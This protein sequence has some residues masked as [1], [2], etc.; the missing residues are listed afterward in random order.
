M[1]RERYARHRARAARRQQT[2]SKTGREIGPPPPIRDPQRRHAAQTSLAQFAKTYFPNTFYLPFCPDHLRCIAKLEHATLHGGHFAFALPRGSGKTSLALTAALWAVLHGYRQFVVIIGPTERHALNTL[3]ALRTHLETNDLLAEDYPEVCHPIRALEGITNRCPGQLC[4]NQRTQIQFTSNKIVLPTIAESPASGSILVTASITGQIRGMVHTRPDGHT[5]RPDLAILDDPQ[6]DES[7]ASAYQ[8]ET[9]A[10]IILGAV[11]GLAGPN[12]NI[13]AVMPC[14]CIAPHDL[15]SRFL[16]PQLHPEWQPEKTKLVYAWPTA[17]HMWQHYAELRAKSL[18]E[19]GNGA[20]ATAYYQAHRAEMD[21]GAHVAWPER[22]NP[23]EISGLQH[24]WNLRLRDPAAFA[25][26]YQNEPIDTSAPSDQIT[27]AHLAIRLSPYH[28]GH[29]P[30][31]TRHLTAGIDV[32]STLLYWTLC[33]WTDSLGGYLLDYGTYPQQTAHHFT[34]RNPTISITDAHPGSL[35]HALAASIRTLA[36][37]LAA[38]Y[39]PDLILIDANWATSTPIV[40]AYCAENPKCIPAHGRYLGARSQPITAARPKPREKLGTHWRLTPTQAGRRLTYDTNFWKSCLRQR[41]TTHTSD[42]T[43]LLFHGPGP[44]EHL[45]QHL[46]SEIPRT[47]HAHDR[48]VEE[49]HLP[50]T[51]PDNHWLDALVLALVAASVQGAAL[52]GTPQPKPA[53]API[54][55]SQQ[56]AQAAQRRF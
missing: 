46:C 52:P 47:V 18:R 33:A 25:A 49:W 37:A 39:D 31:N 50:P 56:Y 12:R 43:A 55:F 53:P 4:L 26:E 9:R 3:A 51:R 16:D 5:V 32:Q 35:E 23:D 34:A 8:T 29:I 54:S 20:E 2:I 27:P 41:L 48:T 7:A 10:R 13:T 17:E 14:T 28:R 22:H 42:P 40:Q 30:H 45:A 19:G 15:A 44:H 11:L 38:Q 24:A 36:A 6:T 21:A 1:D